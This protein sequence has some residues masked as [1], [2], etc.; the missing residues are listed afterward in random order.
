MPIVY[1]ATCSDCG[2]ADPVR[3]EGYSA[4]IVDGP[5]PSPFVH[6]EEGRLVVLAH[7]LESMIMEEL[8]L[9]HQSAALGGRL[10]RVRPVICPACGT[11]Y[12]LR[13]L[14]AGSAALGCSGCL[15]M[16]G[17][18]AGIGV[19]V[20]WHGHSFSGGLAA[21]WFSVWGIVGFAEWV[22]DRYVRQR[23]QDRARTFDRGPGCP[24]CGCAKVVAFRWRWRALPCPQCGERTLRVRS[25]GIS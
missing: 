9:S 14:S 19:L 4:V 20:G 1:Q 2:Y 8:G 15:G 22:T 5:S 6:P 25:V 18:G 10:V 13:R 11:S 3:S 17:A 7:P 24:R 12:E 21:G 23:Y 16:L